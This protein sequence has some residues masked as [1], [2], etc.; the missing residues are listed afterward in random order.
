MRLV[1][2]TQTEVAEA[3][4]CFLSTVGLSQLS[5]LTACHNIKAN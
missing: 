4:P 1:S 2:S 5:A 3:A